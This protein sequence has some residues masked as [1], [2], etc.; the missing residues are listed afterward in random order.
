[1]FT[2][3][4][5]SA[6]IAAVHIIALPVQAFVVPK[7]NQQASTFTQKRK[8]S[9]ST[10]LS[11]ADTPEDSLPNMKAS[12]MKK[13]LES[14]GISTKSMFDRKEFEKALIEA[15]LDDLKKRRKSKLTNEKDKKE[16]T[17]VDSSET[18]TT[19]MWGK[20]KKKK[21]KNDDFREKMSSTW[22]NVASTAKNVLETH[23]KK[24]SD[25][26]SSKEKSTSSKKKSAR[27]RRFELAMEEG[28]A[29]KLSDLKNELTDRG[30]SITSFF[31]KSDLID[32]YANAIAENVKKLEY[33]TKNDKKSSRG[34][35]KNT[36]KKSSNYRNN[37]NFDPSYKDVVMHAFDPSS[38]L[39]GDVIIDITET[40]TGH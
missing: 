40:T 4:F 26:S 36:K 33:E 25:N 37:E 13:E 34:K 9:P 20:T 5:I 30:I 31:E 10:I 21:E 14:F 11:Y 6:L 3:Q 28:R 32:A 27:Q 2:V 35:K 24:S 18:D 15:R 7:Y 16:T 8:T 29:M 38:I 12:E 19:S 22:K 1:M 23:K 17:S 39:P